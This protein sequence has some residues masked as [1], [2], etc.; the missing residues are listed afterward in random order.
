[1]KTKYKNKKHIPDL[2]ERVEEFLHSDTIPAT[3]TKYTLMFLA[4]GAIVFGGAI[5]PG[6][7]R[8]MKGSGL[9]EEE[10]GF[11]EKQIKNALYSLK[12]DKLVEII[13]DD[14]NKVSVKLTNKGK[15]RIRKF[16]IDT[17]CIKKP[18][19][20]DGKWRILMFDIPTKPKVYNLAREALRSKIKELGFYQMQKSV[21][22]YPYECED[23]ILFIAEAFSVER[24]IE[25]VTSDKLLY[26]ENLKSIFGV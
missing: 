9:L 3:A 15:E 17:V 1:M 8:A 10:T 19:K 22:V 25:I 16:S 7:L 12:K 18:K 23:E 2:K 24:Y 13:R 14:K 6:V 20:W 4:L 11:G 21:W 5:V 26:G